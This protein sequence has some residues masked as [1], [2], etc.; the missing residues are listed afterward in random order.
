MSVLYFD[1]SEHDLQAHDDI[2]LGGTGEA[3]VSLQRNILRPDKATPTPRRNE[4][5]TSSSTGEVKICGV[6]LS[7]SWLVVRLIA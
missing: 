1:E 3:E 7:I 2:T 4:V 6:E 5:W